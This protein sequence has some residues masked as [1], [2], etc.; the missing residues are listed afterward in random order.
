MCLPP[1]DLAFA[2]PYTF[3]SI[4]PFSPTCVCH[5]QAPHLRKAALPLPYPNSPP[6]HPCPSPHLQCVSEPLSQNPV[7][8]YSSPNKH[9]CPSHI[10]C[11]PKCVFLPL[12]PSSS[13]ATTTSIHQPTLPPSL[14]KKLHPPRHT[15]KAYR[16]K[17]ASH[18]AMELPRSD[19][20]S[21]STNPLFTK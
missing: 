17:G 3:T 2:Q 7:S 15:Y 18:S 16:R 13:S 9:L 1:F 19:S 6:P 14:A 11:T 12:L 8:S 21:C 10:Q 5:A 4:S 20:A